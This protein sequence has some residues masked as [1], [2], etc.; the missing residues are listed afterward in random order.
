MADMVH[1]ISSTPSKLAYVEETICTA[2]FKSK[3]A[4][5]SFSSSSTSV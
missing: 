1:I 3:N 2:D 5:K 4:N